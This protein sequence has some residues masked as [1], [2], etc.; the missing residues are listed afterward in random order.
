MLDLTGIRARAVTLLVLAALVAGSG[1]FLDRVVGARAEPRGLPGAGLSGASFCPHGG[2]AGWKG[3]VVVTNP[4]RRRVRVRLTQ[5]NARGTGSVSTFTIGA[6][7]Q[8]YRQVPAEDP[9]DSTLVE[10]FGGWI[11]ATSILATG[12]PGGLAA[13]A[14]DQGAHRNWFVMDLPTSAG[15]TS[16]LVLMNPF[17]EPAQFD[18]VLRTEE[19]G[20]APGP[21]SPYVLPPGRSVAIAVNDFLLL[22][23][24]EESL[25]AR[26][27]QRMGRVVAGGLTLSGTG[28]R[29]EPGIAAAGTRWVIPAAGD[30]GT[31]QL[32]ILNSGDARADLSVA[33]EGSAAQRLVSGPEGFSVGPGNVKTFEP[34]RVKDAGYLVASSNGRAFVA[35]LRLAGPGGDTATIEGSAATADRWLVLPAVP[36]SGGRSFLV[37]QNPGRGRVDVAIHL[38]GSGGPVLGG[39]ASRTLLPGRTIRITLPSQEGPVSAVVTARGGTI[40]ASAASYSPDL[41][42]FASTLGLPMKY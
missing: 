40:V 17:Q 36:P 19:R 38:L 32:I 28:I 30:A 15:Q 1:V 7:R 23:P 16:Y 2:H 10:Y 11:G 24:T 20:V 13:M 9:A 3:W 22:G 42:G 37:L 27:V 34:E 6:Q 21:L 26:V 29:A 39:P 41:A 18:V 35:A 8:A 25:T 5:L 31:R 4:G 33:A 12:T 14:C